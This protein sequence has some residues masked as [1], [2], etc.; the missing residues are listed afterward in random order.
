MAKIENLLRYALASIGVV[1]ALIHFAPAHAAPHS[2][3][4]VAFAPKRC[5]DIAAKSL[6]TSDENTE[7]GWL[8]VPLQH[9][10][11]MG[12]K[13]ELGVVILRA[14]GNAPQLDPLFM[15]QGGP[16]GSTIESY[17]TTLKDSPIRQQRDIVLFD[18]RGTKHTKPNLYCTEF[19][20]LLLR[21]AEL[22]IPDD[23][24]QQQ[25]L[26][27]A[28][29]CRVRLQKDGVNLNAF[30]S[31]ENAA[32]VNALREALSYDQINF[33]G[34]S[35][36]TLLGQHV[37][38]GFP[39]IL[40]SVILD[41]VV[42]PRQSFIAEA[43][44]SE[45]DALTQL[46]EACKADTTCNTAYP[47][48]ERTL[49]DTSAR[50]NQTPARVLM[51]DLE[52]SK[53]YNTVVD[54][55]ALQQFVF[56]SLYATDLLPYLP[57]MIFEA[58]K[59]N[60]APLGNVGSLFVF[61][62]SVSTG[63]YFSMTCA[64]DGNFDPN[65]VDN[66]GIRPQVAERNVRD[67]KSL[68]ETCAMWNVALLPASADAPIESDIPTLLL[69]GR[70]DPITPARNADDVAR[71]L[72]NATS[73]VFPNTGHGAFQSEPCATGIVEAFLADPATKPDGSCVNMLQP[74][75]FKT[76]AD[77]VPVPVLAQLLSLN[78]RVRLPAALVG[79]G[80]LLL[81]S[82]W[83][84]IPLSWLF[85]LVMNRTGGTLPALAKAM[86]WLTLLNGAVLAVFFGVIT[87]VTATLIRDNDYLFLFGLPVSS[88]WAFV[89]PIVSVVLTLLVVMGTV[90]G[91]RSNGWGILRKINRTVLALSS[92]A[93]MV[94]LA[95]M[96]LLRL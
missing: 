35:Y 50:L 17:A 61:D 52:T 13:I 26:E 33:Y 7:C 83:L 6:A 5:E 71:T 55:D 53:S 96:G 81:L 27:A 58:S 86:P 4:G 14:Q 10:D 78:E 67:L 54:G 9:S 16:G 37:M 62:R 91:L 15:A 89:L 2:Q 47:E 8:T 31:V 29:A 44:R 43:G 79:I 66:T 18:Q 56:Q 12:E 75:Q 22:D 76:R 65:A 20:D 68:R 24:A 3:S 59:G 63:M 73:F 84:V 30:D 57:F 60:H 46:F 39:Q 80:L 64:E 41:G 28:Q 92:I 23:E 48:L 88:A 77:I 93:C 42:A 69:S 85:R 25:G 74:P 70:F 21:T 11:P 72:T 32:D 49:Y 94:G 90:A 45:N 1:T 36:G 34:V 19:D 38:R 51:S 87:A 82:A 40:R 95:M